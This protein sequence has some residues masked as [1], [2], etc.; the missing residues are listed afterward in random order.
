MPNND[1]CMYIH[2]NNWV[3]LKIFVLSTMCRV[4]I[5]FSNKRS[6]KVCGDKDGAGIKLVL[7]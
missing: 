2:I 7:R 4:T 5:I 3:V 6:T 1:T